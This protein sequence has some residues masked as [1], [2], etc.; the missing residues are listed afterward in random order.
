[1][2]GYFYPGDHYFYHW[3]FCGCSDLK[4]A[5]FGADNLKDFAV[6]GDNDNHDELEH[7]FHGSDD[8][9]DDNDDFG[10][11]GDDDENGYVL[12]RY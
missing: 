8:D 7:Y 11:G 1:M 5:F 6:D 9:D 4:C 2:N 3:T 10:G 12:P